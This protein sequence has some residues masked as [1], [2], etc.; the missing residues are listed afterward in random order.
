MAET[1]LLIASVAGAG[2]SAISAISGGQQRQQAF[3]QQAEADRRNAEQA[4]I[5]AGAQMNQAEAEAQRTEGVTRRRVA[6]AFNAAGASGGDT[7]YGSPLDLMGDIAA[8]GALDAQ[9]ARYK[10][11]AAG[12]ASLA[13][14]GSLDAQAGYADSAAGQAGTAGFVQAGATLLGGVASYSAAKLRM[15]QPYGQAAY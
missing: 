3:E 2:L 1:A 12:N 4:R 14:A 8:E 15:G 9:I 5:N 11:R 6:S 10:G 7:S 13:Q